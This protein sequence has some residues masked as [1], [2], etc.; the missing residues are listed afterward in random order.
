MIIIKN[1]VIK[2]Q[3]LNKEVSAFTYFE[4][5]LCL[6]ITCFSVIILT[7][8]VGTVFEKVTNNLF[9]IEFENFYRHSQKIS[10]L[11]R[12]AGTMVF[13]EKSISYHNETITL[14]DTIRLGFVNKVKIN[15]FGGNHSLSKINFISSDETV[16]YTLNLGSGT[17]KKTKN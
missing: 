5:L 1:T 12:V 16:T 8:S 15:Q 13:K 9:Y 11:K 2:S 6:V 4:S 10:I 17:Y 14:P 3:M 7:T